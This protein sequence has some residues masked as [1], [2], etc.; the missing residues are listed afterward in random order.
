M[1]GYSRNVEKRQGQP[2]DARSLPERREDSA[3]PRQLLSEDDAA[4][5][6]QQA[7]SGALV[8]FNNTGLGCTRARA[9][10][11]WGRAWQPI[12]TE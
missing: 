7:E 3:L 6:P 1:Y 12:N 9:R 2:L 5:A 10:H 4:A 11:Y 8:R